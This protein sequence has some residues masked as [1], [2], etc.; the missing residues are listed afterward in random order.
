MTPLLRPLLASLLLSA[1]PVAG[2][3]LAQDAG[4][5]PPIRGRADEMRLSDTVDLRT[6]TQDSREREAVQPLDPAQRELS[7]DLDTPL[8]DPAEAQP[9]ARPDADAADP[10]EA[11][12]LFAGP[13]EPRRENLPHSTRQA[14]P[15]QPVDAG[16]RPARASR[17]GA[18]A[19]LDGIA[20]ADAEL[21]A[22]ETELRPAAADLPPDLFRAV[23]PV[24]SPTQDTQLGRQG[25]AGLDDL[26]RALPR[27]QDDPFAPL[28]LRLGSFTL[29]S[30]LAQ[31]F[32]TSDNL[33]NTLDGVRGAFSETS[34]SVRLLSNWD[35]HEAEINAL[36]SFRRNDSGPLQ[37][38]PRI[39]VDARLR[40]DMSRDW[41]ATL[42]GA[43]RFDR[44]DPLVSG[45]ATAEASTRDILAYSAGATLARDVGRLHNQLDLSA[46]REDRDDGLFDGA[47]R[48]LDDSFTTWSAGLRTGYDVTPA[49]RPFVSASVGRRLFDETLLGSPSRDSVIP[50]LRGG[51][52]FDWG[53]KLSGDVAVGYAWNVPDDDRLG[54]EA[55][56]TID[57]R[58]NW[59]PRRGTDV[60]LQ[61]ETFFEPDTSGLATS[62][63]YQASLGLRHRATA[64]IDLEGRLIAG[65]RDGAVAG[66]ENLYAAETGLTYWLSRYLAVTAR[67][68]YDRFDSPLP[69]L[70]YDANTFRLGVRLQ[71]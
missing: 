43:L 38:V 11:L 20:S 27:T 65:L 53:E 2:L 10:A 45:P 70:D 16:V 12:D 13:P 47:V 41:T 4:D 9:P 22:D 3:A 62:T 52:G 8:A 26:R 68:R 63:L 21:A 40:L 24:R 61:A 18:A 28:G 67:Y 17:T 54:T 58:V 7:N 19:A 25:G 48:R 35:R 5:V 36:A 32:G 71:R 46:V 57:A 42:R 66:D 31:S 59:S 51:V 34:G 23:G 55:S 50:A 69:G 49:L 1:G 60:L 56:P 29:Y 39:D 37:D 44:D 30:A 64:R 33:T 14:A 6:Q 15:A